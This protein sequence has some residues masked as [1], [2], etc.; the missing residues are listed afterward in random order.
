M[1]DFTTFLLSIPVV[2][3]AAAVVFLLME[4]KRLK[5]LEMEVVNTQV[6]NKEVS[7][8]N[9]ELMINQRDLEEELG[10]E[11][12]KN[13]VL[14]SQKKSSETRLGQISEH[15]IPM[16][17]G[18]RHN[19]KDMHFLG[20]PVDYIVFDLDLGKIV[21]LEVKSGNSKASKRQK[22]IKNIIK[23]GRVEYEELRIN[24]KGVKS[25]VIE[26]DEPEKTAK[27]NLNM[28]LRKNTKTTKH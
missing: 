23:T 9:R 20:N 7:E 15:L 13:R 22:T 28:A 19:P 10:K 17:E 16:L 25:K 8:Y 1:I 6:T 2:I 4:R 11:R 21:F 26:P 3:L 18:N 27:T 24:E 12:E 5:N 14:L